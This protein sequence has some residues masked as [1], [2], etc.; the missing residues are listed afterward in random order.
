MT[1]FLGTSGPDGSNGDQSSDAS[2]SSIPL[3]R[4]E[5]RAREQAASVAAMPPPALPQQAP[6]PVAP[7]PAPHLAALHIAPPTVAALPAPTPTSVDVPQPTFTT[8]AV[9]SFVT[10][11]VDDISATDAPSRR[12]RGPKKPARLRPI[13]PPRGTSRP[14]KVAPASR[15]PPVAAS[16]RRPLKRRIL[17]KLL[18]F[19]A[20]AG[21]GLMMV[22]TSVP[23]NA[24]YSAADQISTASVAA[25]TEV[26]VQSIR[27]E[28]SV[29]LALA[30]DSYTATSFREQLFLRYGNRTFLYSNNP[31]GSIQWPFPIAVPISSGFGDRVAPC[32]WC[33]SGHEGVDF[34][35]GAGVTIQSIADGVV[36]TVVTSN[37][38]F[39]NHVIIDHQIDGQLVQSL[40]AHMANDSIRVAVGQ[41]VKVGDPVG[42][43][44]STGAATG[45]HLHLEIRVNGMLVDPFEWLKAHAN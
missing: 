24:F 13:K 4:R 8:S 39:G 42:Q 40:Y 27:V 23:A 17:S 37:S 32:A 44:G 10:S 11:P 5:L 35:P 38:G 12:A 20:M 22:A 45:A 1:D 36:S 16:K 6:A 19:G 41:V 15:R 30:R 25:P 3:T 34:T 2:N 26:E 29:N 28:P 21:A 33:S 43:V 7:P 9:S 31:N 18:A 14:R